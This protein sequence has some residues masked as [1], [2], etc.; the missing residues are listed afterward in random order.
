MYPLAKLQKIVA[1]KQEEGNQI[2]FTNGC[3]D[4]L[5]VGHT[6]YLKEARNYGDLLI[7]GL[8]SDASV[9][10]LKGQKRPLI[11]DEERAEMLANLEMVDYI[12][13]FPE[14]TANNV[15]A[16]L[17]PDI[18]AKGGDY[19]IEELPEAEV[20]SSY[21]GQIELVPEVKGASTTEI[22]NKILERYT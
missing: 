16:T 4:L 5:H 7:V 17:K 2:V 13:I 8:N 6:R 10:A 3:F 1:S 12:T 11:P 9:K 20:V 19:Q 21:G 22:I 18:Y 15:I 14:Q